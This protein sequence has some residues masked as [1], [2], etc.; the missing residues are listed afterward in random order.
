[1]TKSAHLSWVSP[2]HSKNQT[3]RIMI[4]LCKQKVVKKVK[5]I[6]AKNVKYG[7]FYD[8]QRLV[9]LYNYNRNLHHSDRTIQTCRNLD[10]IYPLM[11]TV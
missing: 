6:S 7:V 11:A 1:M 9:T 3:N 10:L 4:L 8:N 2:P 5:R